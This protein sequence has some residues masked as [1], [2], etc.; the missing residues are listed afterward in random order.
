MK[1][2]LT[3]L[4]IVLFATTIAYF[5]VRE[6]ASRP[7]IE[8]DTTPANSID[9]TARREFFDLLDRAESELARGELLLN[10]IKRYPQLHQEL[11][12]RSPNGSET[13]IKAKLS[14]EAFRESE[15]S[16]LDLELVEDISVLVEKIEFYRKKAETVLELKE[17][18]TIKGASERSIR[19]R[20]WLNKPRTGRGG[21]GFA[22]M[23]FPFESLSGDQGLRLPAR[24]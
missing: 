24:S 11:E 9:T 20:P 23:R 7:D 12:R 1:S 15:E 21:A 16:S 13:L 18:P 14:I 4:I 6:P 8:A 10:E 3:G 17:E 5:F 2:T 22:I 19:M